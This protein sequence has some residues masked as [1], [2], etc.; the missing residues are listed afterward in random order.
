MRGNAFKCNSK[1]VVSFEIKGLIGWDGDNVVLLLVDLIDTQTKYLC[2]EVEGT[3]GFLTE[4][5]DMSLVARMGSS[6]ASL[7]NLL[8]SHILIGNVSQV[9]YPGFLEC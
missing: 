5:M 6:L 9:S 8:T 1:W 7:L 2:M 4:P 3:K